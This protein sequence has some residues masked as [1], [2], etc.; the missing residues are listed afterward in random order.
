MTAQSE[1]VV[2]QSSDAFA[3]S[4]DSS[5][6]MA[7]LKIFVSRLWRISLPPTRTHAKYVPDLL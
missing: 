1:T 2:S 3:R 7:T 5:F 4:V 6:N